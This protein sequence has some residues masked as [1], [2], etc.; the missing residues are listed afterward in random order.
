MTTLIRS[1]RTRVRTWM[2]RLTLGRAI[3]TIVLVATVMVVAG[4]VLVRIVEP[5]TFTS[6]GLA[7]WWSVT[8]VTTVGYG[9]VVPVSTTGRFVGAALMLMGVSLIPLV[10]SVAVSILT[11]KRAQLIEA[12]QEERLIQI[13]QRL[14]ALQPA[15]PPAAPPS[16]PSEAPPPRAAPS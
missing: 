1:D 9:D 13:E 15:S 16:E 12:E 7:F 8:T 3:R 14:A 4:G 5:G 6:I 10:T 11:A 2:E